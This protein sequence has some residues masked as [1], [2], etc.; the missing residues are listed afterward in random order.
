MLLE[1]MKKAPF[2]PIKFIEKA[3]TEGGGWRWGCIHES[4]L[5]LQEMHV[6]GDWRQQHEAVGE[7]HLVYHQVWLSLHIIIENKS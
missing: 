1:S 2:L 7:D 3:R 4:L 5:L 6:T